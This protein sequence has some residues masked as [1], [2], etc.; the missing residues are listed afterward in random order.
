MGTRF[1]N[2][3]VDGWHQNES[4]EL[5]ASVALEVTNQSGLGNHQGL[6]RRVAVKASAKR[7]GAAVSSTSSRSSCSMS[8][9]ETPLR[10]EHGSADAIVQGKQRL[11]LRVRQAD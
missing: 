3:H 10:A 5:D 7:T 4:I 6:F 2:E 11:G 1:R 8:T 9:V